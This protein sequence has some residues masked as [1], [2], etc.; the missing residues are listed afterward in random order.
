MIKAVLFDLDNTLI[1]FIS[2]KRSASRAAAKAMVKAG[3]NAKPKELSK[4][5]FDFYLDYGIESDDA[6][7]KFLEKKVGVAEPKILAAGLNAYLKEKYLHLKPY[8]GVLETLAK[9]QKKGLKIGLVSDGL[10]LK[11]WMRLNEAGLD[12]YFDTVITYEDT[13]EKKPS[14]KPFLNACKALNVKPNECLMVGDWPEKD[15]EGAKALGMTTVLAGYGGRSTK[16]V[17]ADYKIKMINELEDI[18]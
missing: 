11:A 10:R 14:K 5:L 13:G 2:M 12:K 8:P 16:Q 6:F 15:I 17:K 9:L 4:E 18:V 1:D 7:T 3:L